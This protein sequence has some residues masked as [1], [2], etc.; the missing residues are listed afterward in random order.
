MQPA[1]EIKVP[2]ATERIPATVSRSATS[3]RSVASSISFLGASSNGTHISGSLKIVIPAAD[4]EGSADKMEEMSVPPSPLTLPMLQ[5]PTA[6]SM[7]QAVTSS[8]IYAHQMEDD[9]AASPSRDP[10]DG[11]SGRRPQGQEGPNCPPKVDHRGTDEDVQGGARPRRDKEAT[12]GP[13]RLGWTQ[14]GVVPSWDPV[15]TSTWEELE[16]AA[17]LS[18]QGTT[19]GAMDYALAMLSQARTDIE[20]RFR[21]QSQALQAGRRR[22]DAFECPDHVQHLMGQMRHL[23]EQNSCLQQQVRTLME[24]REEMVRPQIEALERTFG[25]NNQMEELRQERDRLQQQLD[26]LQT[27]PPAIATLP[28]SASTAAKETAKSWKNLVDWLNDDGIRIQKER[29]KL[30]DQVE[31]LQT[32]NQQQADDLAWANF[33]IDVCREQLEK[34]KQAIQSAKPDA[35]G[36]CYTIRESTAYTPGDGRPCPTLHHIGPLLRAGGYT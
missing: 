33:T 28:A 21:H 3:Q 18:V 15:E 12:T 35:S 36:S 14:P 11:S 10:E 6:S 1:T 23:W 22:S 24:E 4:V 32:V 2:L 7:T 26:H 34:L 16:E 29:K 9:A 17:H 20:E 5:G 31:Q 30:N 8:V 13:S 19:E 25:L 27:E